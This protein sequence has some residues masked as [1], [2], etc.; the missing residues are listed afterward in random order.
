M[1]ARP[2]APPDAGGA[3]PDR[4]TRPPLYKGLGREPFLRGVGHYA[5]VFATR[6]QQK[7]ST[8]YFASL[9]AREVLD[10]VRFVSRFH[11][12]GEDIQAEAPA[13]DDVGQFISKIERS[14]AAF[15][16]PLKKR[17]IRDLVSFYESV[18]DQ[19]AIP[20]TVLLVTRD[21]LRFT[22]R[23]G[24]FGVLSEPGE[25]FDIIDGQHRLAALHFFG[26]RLNE[27]GKSGIMDNINVPALIFDGKSADH[28]AEM[29]VT[30]NATQTRINRSHLVDLL[31]KV[32][33]ARPEEKFAAK[34]VKLLYEEHRSPL[35]Y[36][37]NMLGGR[38]KQEKWILQS[39]LYNE[40]LK[41][42]GGRDE[43]R[44]RAPFDRFDLRA[45]RA[46]PFV[47]SYLRAVE[48]AFGDTWG[49]REYQ[50]TSA[51]ALKAYFRILPRVMEDA[52]VMRRWEERGDAAAIVP[53]VAPFAEL[54]EDLRT[55][56]FFNRWPAKGQLERVRL[57]EKELA[58]RLG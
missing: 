45:E 37:I 46:F 31:E 20:G 23:E 48:D 42:A 53:K 36:R 27:Q 14:D 9:N 11:F 10:R 52:Q 34:L 5:P 4:S 1:T 54:K 16:R 47:A 13:D 2:P 43:K 58:K 55:E 30:I 51:V 56:G 22:P 18:S 44:K 40:I 29:F 41:L 49:K 6:I 3:G 33:L 25:K 57:I 17:K 8:F 7:D 26:R 19:P 50:V 21:T 38:S 39:E 28:A 24:N 32:T 15:Q 35:R 12:E